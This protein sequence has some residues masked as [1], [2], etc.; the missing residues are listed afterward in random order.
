MF[1]SLGYINNLF[2][3]IFYKKLKKKK[4]K[5]LSLFYF[6]IKFFKNNLLIYIT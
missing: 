6:L 4:Q 2:Y 1:A 5:N 3:K